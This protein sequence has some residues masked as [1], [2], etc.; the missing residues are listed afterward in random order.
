MDAYLYGAA[1]EV[2]ATVATP[3]QTTAQTVS[4]SSS[5]PGTSG[6]PRHVNLPDHIGQSR[7]PLSFGIADAAASGTASSFTTA[8]AVSTSP[9]DAAH[10]LAYKVLRLPVFAEVFWCRFF[11]TGFSTIRCIS[12]GG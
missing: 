7:L 6:R 4:P 2:V 10:F 5:V 11:D 9:V 12:L 3:A 8:P 1:G